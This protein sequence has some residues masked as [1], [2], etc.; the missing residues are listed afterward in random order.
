MSKTPVIKKS[1]RPKPNP[2]TNSQ[3]NSSK[4]P[5]QNPRLNLSDPF[6]EHTGGN[7]EIIKIKKQTVKKK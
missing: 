7:V 6:G 3:M 2:K 1:P 4:K 5:K